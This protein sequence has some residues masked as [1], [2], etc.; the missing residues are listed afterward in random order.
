MAANI[1]MALRNL[2]RQKGRT[3]MLMVAIGFGVMVVTLL[4]SFT[5]GIVDNVQGT[6]SRMLGG[7]IYITGQKIVEDGRIISG[8]PEDNELTNII[9]ETGIRAEDITRRS[10]ANATIIFGSSSATQRIEGVDWDEE[11]ALRSSLTVVKGDLASVREPSS[12]IVTEKVADQLNVRAGDQVIVKLQTVTGQQNVGDFVIGAVI[13]DPGVGGMLSAYADLGYLNGLLNLDPQAYQQLSI[14]LRNPATMEE[15][16]ARIYSGLTA[17]GPVYP[18]D[19]G[20]NAG[21]NILGAGGPGVLT[22]LR[23]FSVS[24]LDSGESPWQGI[25][26]RITTLNDLTTQI[27]DIVSVLNSVSLVVLIVLMII[28]MVAI[29][30]TF[31]MIVSERTAEIGTMRA[32]GMQRPAVR[33]M[34]LTEASFL[35]TGSV[36]AGILVAL[37]ATQ[38]AGLF[39]FSMDSALYVMTNQGRLTFSFKPGSILFDA[40]LVMLMA[41]GAAS[42]PVRRAT[43]LTPSEALRET[44]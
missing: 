15:D 33:N 23:G 34:F 10:L 8:I 5:T 37:I 26:Y 29:T 25:R 20:A 9:A 31:R 3:S 38:V 12:L 36:V 27:Q 4:N 42:F 44:R 39:T 13:T 22:F 35:A 43:L 19:M 40:L 28:V 1:K 21:D 14:F 41:M 30:N 17:L 18:R 32:L 16:A 6:V 24:T 7:H 11:K 2:S